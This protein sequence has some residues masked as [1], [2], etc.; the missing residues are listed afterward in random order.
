MLQAWIE[1]CHQMFGGWEVQTMWNLQTNKWCTRRSWCKSKKGLQLAKT[2]VCH[3]NL[4]LKRHS[5]LC[6]HTESPI[7]KKFR[8]H[9]LVK[10]VMLI[11]KGT[12][13]EHKKTNYYR[14]PWIKGNCKQCFQLPTLFVKFVSPLNDPRIYSYNILVCQW[15]FIK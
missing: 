13:L 1:V 2:W 14:P 6:K 5:M 12:F 15:C 11:W 4:E 9:R 7:K 3:Y 10:K 8:A